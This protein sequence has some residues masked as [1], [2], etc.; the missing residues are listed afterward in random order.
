[1]VKKV[2]KSVGI[3]LSYLNITVSLLLV[4]LEYG[5]SVEYFLI[6]NIEVRQYRKY[7]YTRYLTRDPIWSHKLPSET[8]FAQTHFHCEREDNFYLDH[9]N[10]L[11]EAELSPPILHTM[12]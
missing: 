5:K 3:D 9:A 6:V 8:H 4:Y 7:P 11:C 10:A 1:M 12:G 2:F